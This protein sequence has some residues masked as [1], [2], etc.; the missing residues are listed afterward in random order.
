MM[1]NNVVRKEDIVAALQR[2]G[3]TAGDLV[4]V[5]SSMKSLGTVEDGAQTVIDAFDEVLTREGTLVVPTFCQVDLHHAYESWY[6]DKPSDTG[7]LTEYFRKQMYVYRSNHPTHSVAARGKLARELTKEHAAYG[8]HCSAFGETSFADSSPW[9]KLPKMGGKIVLLGVRTG[10]NTMK[11]VLESNICE[12][13]ISLIKDPVKAEEQKKKLWFFLNPGPWAW[14][15]TDKLTDIMREKGLIT[16][17]DCGGCHIICMEAQ[18]F[19]DVGF[20]VLT[21][22]PES[23]FDEEYCSWYRDCKALF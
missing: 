8:P 16:E 23:W 21:A 9:R 2:L 4:M 15:S 22:D 3:L 11:H 20:E 17:T 14:F 10:V 6:M 7:Y 1:E 12:Y 5:H 18:S 13:F 19:L